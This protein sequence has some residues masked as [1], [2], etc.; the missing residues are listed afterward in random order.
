MKGFVILMT[1]QT[2]IILASVSG[3]LLLIIAITAVKTGYKRPAVLENSNAV[4][5]QQSQLTVQ[6]PTEIESSS[7]PSA[8]DL[9]VELNQTSKS[10]SNTTSKPPANNPAK[11]ITT[12]TPSNSTSSNGDILIGGGGPTEPQD[13]IVDG[14]KFKNAD[15]YAYWQNWILKG[16]DYCGAH[17][18]VAFFSVD[19]LGYTSYNW[20]NCPQYS[21]EKDPSYYCQ[22]CHLP[23]GLGF[24]KCVQYINAC[25]CQ[26][27]GVWVE[28]RTCHT[29]AN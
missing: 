20:R 18:C 12:S 6:I 13:Y 4:S 29:C 2:K 22:S 3:L 28:S 25:Y 16:C 1:K 8:Q 9:N 19:A 5:S 21:I 17:D 26:R 11:P 7:L 27:C 15:N 23:K 24:G 10:S 14:R